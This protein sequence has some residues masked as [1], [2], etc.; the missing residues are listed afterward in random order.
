MKGH[1]H[2]IRG[3]LDW[4][5]AADPGVV[6]A[7]QQIY[8]DNM[9]FTSNF[10]VVRFTVFP[11]GPAY[12]SNDL[13][14]NSTSLVVLA[15][16]KTGAIAGVTSQPDSIEGCTVRDNRQIGWSV[17]DSAGPGT[18]QQP[19]LDPEHLVVSDLWINGWKINSGTGVPYTLNQPISYIIVLEAVTTTLDVALLTLLRERAQDTLAP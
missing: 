5:H 4:T 6:L 13:W 9:D 11:T 17:W 15:T 8:L 7:P 3:T 19:V 10:K 18:M 1:L 16:K 12:V 2:T 14:T